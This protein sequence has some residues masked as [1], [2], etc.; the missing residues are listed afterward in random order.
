MNNEIQIRIALI[1]LL[2]LMVILL[3]L[4]LSLDRAEIN[5]LEDKLEK[6]Q[7]EYGYLEEMLEGP[8]TR[9]FE[10]SNDFK[11]KIMEAKAS[12]T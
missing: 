7:R 12:H 9:G 3:I 2:S 10:E 5:G 11:E 4:V 1:S 8:L 6:S